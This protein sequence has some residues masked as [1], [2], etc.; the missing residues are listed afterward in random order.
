[1]RLRY[2]LLVGIVAA[3]L[4]GLAIYVGS[5]HLDKDTFFWTL[6]VLVTV[7]GFLAPLGVYKKHSAKRKD[8]LGPEGDRGP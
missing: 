8:N 6:L 2:R 4:A 3:I 5:R 7:G 1:M